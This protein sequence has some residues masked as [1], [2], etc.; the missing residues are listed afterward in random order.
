MLYGPLHEWDKEIR[1][2]GCPT[3]YVHGGHYLRLGTAHY[4][5]F[6]RRPIVRFVEDPKRTRQRTYLHP[7]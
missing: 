6:Y 3:A 5:G 2:V 7:Y 4:M 1:I